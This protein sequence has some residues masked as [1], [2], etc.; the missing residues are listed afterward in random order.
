MDC[1]QSIWFQMPEVKLKA[2]TRKQMDGNGVSRKR[3][4]HNYIKVLAWQVV[5]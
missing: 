1:Q 5:E 4:R 3:V 2:F